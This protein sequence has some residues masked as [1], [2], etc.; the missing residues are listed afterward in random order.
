M[1][2]GRTAAE[3]QLRDTSSRPKAD[4][5]SRTD[6]SF[7]ALHIPGVLGITAGAATG[8]SRDRRGGVEQVARHRYTAHADLR[9]R[10][11]RSLFSSPYERKRM[12]VFPLRRPVELRAATASSRVAMVP[13]FVRNHPSPHPRFS[14]SP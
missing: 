9:V 7:N 11:D 13:M 5:T 12:I 1:R 6:V 8:A 10:K 2:G 4:L 3:T 14:C